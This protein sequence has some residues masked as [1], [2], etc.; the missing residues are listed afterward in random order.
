MKKIKL[1]LF[2]KLLILS[3]IIIGVFL[4][5]SNYNKK[6]IQ[7]NYDKCLKNNDTSFSTIDID[8]ELTNFLKKYHTSVFYEDIK[9]KKTFKY[10]EEESYYSA[11]IIKIADV[12]LLY[13]NV[14]ENKISLNDHLS[15]LNSIN[16]NKSKNIN[17][18]NIDSL[19]YKDVLKYLIENSDNRAHLLLV[20]NMGFDNVANFQKSL[21]LN[22]YIKDNNYYA[23][24]D[25]HDAEIYLKELYKLLNNK[26]YGKDLYTYF[27]NDNYNYLT[28]KDKKITAV[29]KYGY[30]NTVFHDMGITYDKNPYY[31][32]ILTNEGQNNYEKILPDIANKIYDYHQKY[33]LLKKEYCQ[34]KKD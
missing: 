32:A 33:Y 30:Y 29:H 21:G 2:S 16:L 4:I 22:Y 28:F 25:I 9:T 18:A 14:E 31:V 34:N 17:S 10:N 24:I 3:I 5:I 26:K 19:T 11:S 8:N 20:D 15:N 23:S 12:L 1:T 27:T 6:K 13:K 7:N